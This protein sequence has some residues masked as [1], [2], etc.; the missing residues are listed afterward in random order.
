MLKNTNLSRL[1]MAVGLVVGMSTSAFAQETSSGVRGTITNPSG[2]P[3]A[4]VKI[5]VTHVPSG[6]RRVVITN[7]QGIYTIQGLRVG[8]PYTVEVDS[9]QYRDQTINDLFLQLGEFERINAQLETD[10]VETIVVTGS[11][12]I[13]TN[14]GASSSFGQDAIKGQSGLT[15]DIKD[16]IRANPLVS[17]GTDGARQLSIAGSNPRFNSITVDGISQNDNFGLNAGGFPTQRSPFPLDA[18]DQISVD[19]VPFTVKQGG[20]T[21]GLINA[22]FKSGTNEFHGNVFYETIDDSYAGTPEDEDGNDVDIQFGEKTYGFTLGGPIIK[23]KLFFFLSYQFNDIDTSIDFGPAD[24]SRFANSAGATTA[25]VNEVIR[26]AR[27]VYGLTDAQLGGLDFSPVEEDES[28]VA[29]ID[30]NINDFHRA[31]FTYQF[32]EGNVTSNTSDPDDLRLSSQFYNRGDELNNIS[33]KLYSDWTDSF[34][35]EIAFSIQD[36]DNLQATFGTI[37]EVEIENVTGGGDILFGADRSRHANNLTTKNT[38][39]RVD[40]NYLAGAHSIDF[41]VEFQQLEIF[42]LFIQ[43]ALGTTVFNS[44]EDFANRNVESFTYVN[45]LSNDPNNA[46]AEFDTDTLILFAQDSWDITDS[47]TLNYG[48][49]YERIS[50]DGAPLRNP[51]SIERTGIDNTETLDG[52]DI[53]LPRI[54]F[55]YDIND[56]LTLRGGFGR[57]AGGQPNV[58]ISNSFSNTGVNTARFQQRNFQ[59]DANDLGTIFP[60]AASAIPDTTAEVL[61]QGNEGPVNLIDPD[62]E[63]PN[64]LRYQL[65]LDYQFDIP[66]VGEGFNWTNEVIFVNRNQSAFWVDASLPTVSQSPTSGGSTFV[67]A[68]GQVLFADDD[69]NTDLLLTNADGGRSKIFS[70]SLSKSWDNGWSLSASYANQDITESKAGTSSTATS[71]FRFTPQI[72]RNE[73]FIG[74]GA[75]ETEHRFVVN[76]GYQT[77]FFSGY[78]TNFNL[79]YERRS[80]LPI[81]YTTNF[82]GAFA[83]FGS[84]ST[85]GAGLTPGFFGGD[86]IA[87][88]PTLNDPNVVY[89]N[90]EL[91]AELQAA[92]SERGL[93]GAAGGFLGKGSTKAPYINTLDLSITQEIPGF[94]KGHKGKLTLI[95][96][97]LLN[98]LDSSQGKV[99]T[100]G[101]GTFRLYDVDSIDEQGRYVIDAVRNDTTTFDADDST[102]RLKLGVSYEF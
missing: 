7:A 76:V 67:T 28:Y 27:D 102:W 41:G 42:N 87:Y 99:F 14:A 68:T 64:E 48:L 51:N 62:F 74:T 72:N 63:L 54:S 2:A 98:L 9:D 12:Q 50:V 97:N 53:L 5:T 37:G 92:I 86:F 24:D 34:S 25:E 23:D 1:A 56:V 93:G 95:V 15:R 43:D 61:A 11:R 88:I 22:V 78:E 81:S 58:W 13:F 55:N 26:I 32:N 18:L 20:F 80:G 36:V 16:V 21:G 40:A 70:T 45:G 66:G 39:F 10:A 75:F 82:D 38:T 91:E 8:G 30:W 29:K 52:I 69:N 35:T 59:I 60:A 4:N 65:A 90:P 85:G 3:A 19:T 17:V 94:V 77:E 44:I 6:T 71:N 47:F 33:A 57:F 89:T 79:F 46:A 84:D 31:S 83:N 96:D 73:P 101:F 100:S 49:R